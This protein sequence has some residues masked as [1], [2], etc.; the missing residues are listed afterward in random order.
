MEK[1]D[2]IHR[3]VADIFNDFVYEENCFQLIDEVTRCRRVNDEDQ[4]SCL[5]HVTVNCVNKI[6]KCYTYTIGNSDHKALVIHRDSK[7]LLFKKRTS[8]KRCINILKRN[9]SSE[10]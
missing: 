4:K 10:K 3:E 8:K 9:L 5:D 1:P 2:Y 6:S 7:E